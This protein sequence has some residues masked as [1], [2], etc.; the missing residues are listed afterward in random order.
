MD[1]VYLCSEPSICKDLIVLFET[2]VTCSKDGVTVNALVIYALF[3]IRQ[4]IIIH[5][6]NVEQVV[7]CALLTKR[8][9]V[10]SPIGT[11]FLDE[12]FSGFSSPVRRMSGSFRPPRSPNIIWP[13]LSS[14]L[15][16]YGRQWP[17]MFTRPKT[18]NKQINKHNIN[19]ILTGIVI[20]YITLNRL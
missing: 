5:N 2:Y 3:L 17:E 9:W 6:I 14:I 13:S 18:S 20:Q 16:H 4:S 1:L 8:A 15:I 11:S 10:R 12:V 19:I 7:A